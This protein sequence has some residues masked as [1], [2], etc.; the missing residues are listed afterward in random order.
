MLH[1]CTVKAGLSRDI[2]TG[3]RPAIALLL[4][5]LLLFCA[6]ESPAQT[7]LELKQID[8][9]LKVSE[10][11]LKQNMARRTQTM[12]KI[13]NLEKQIAER[14]LRY[15][16]TRVKADSLS[17][18]AD[19]ILAER[20]ALASE[21]SRARQHL[22]KL[23][24]SAYLMGRQSGLKVALSPQGAQYMTRMN[25]Y[26]R[27]IAD[28][29]QL[30]LDMLVSLQQRLA[31]SDAKLSSQ[32]S[33]MEKLSSALESDRRYLS[34]LK[35]NRMAML[36][37]LDKSIDDGSTEI[38]QLRNRKVKLEKLLADIATRQKIRAARKRAQQKRLQAVQRTSASRAKNAD[39]QPRK[40]AP[41]ELIPGSLPMPVKA[42]IVAR[43]GDKRKNSGVP[44]SG[45]LMEGRDGTRIKAISDG[46]VVYADWL[47]GYGLM[48][49]LDHGNGIM[50]LYGHNKRILKAVGEKVRQSDTIAT[51]GDTAG[52]KS[53]GLYFEIRQNGVA[54]DPLK[55][56]RI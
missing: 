54:Q 6:L 7:T 11:E 42:K 28:A 34:Q 38:A 45:I 41:S 5:L 14:N 10:R 37:K 39:Q 52:L 16:Q 26:A 3:I 22:A 40:R 21:Y 17:I 35:S 55:W 13:Q 18:E 47:P 50:S 8:S 2:I 29:R 12:E 36:K 9:T 33:K 53:A 49:I 19:K 23:L 32:R 15:E 4:S 51:M 46:E 25:H 1:L 20:N 31:A 27:A 43:F 48:V 56:C 30:Q 24:E 44:W